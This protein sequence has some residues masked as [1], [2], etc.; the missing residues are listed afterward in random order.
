MGGIGILSKS[1]D[2]A[3]FDLGK[4]HFSS[5]INAFLI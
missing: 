1:R 3:A 4:N 5:L 2:M